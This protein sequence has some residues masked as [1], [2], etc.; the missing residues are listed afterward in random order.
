[1]P[2]PKEEKLTLSFSADEQKEIEARIC[3]NQAICNL[4][5]GK[6]SGAIT[7]IKHLTDDDTTFMATRMIEKKS[8]ID[9]LKIQGC[10]LTCS[11]LL[12]LLSVPTLTTIDVSDNE[13]SEE[14][15]DDLVKKLNKTSQIKKLNLS[16]N[17][18]NAAAM[19]KLAKLEYIEEL[20]LSNNKIQDQ[21]AFDALAAN[22]VFRVL[23]LRAVAPSRSKGLYAKF[24]TNTALIALDGPAIPSEIKTV[25]TNN[26]KRHVEVARSYSTD[27]RAKNYLQEKPLGEKPSVKAEQD[28]AGFNEALPLYLTKDPQQKTKNR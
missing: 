25:I 20:D 26:K 28:L 19:S 2:D 7:L 15:I 9:N 5:L 21:A 3:V 10:G 24:S 12:P 22:K 1:M 16:K 14:G 23:K 27:L 6:F 18:L 13:L 17:K 8:S 4:H 11:A